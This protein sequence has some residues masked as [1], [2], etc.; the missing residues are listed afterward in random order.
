LGFRTRD[1]RSSRGALR[2]LAAGVGRSAAFAGAIA[3][4][5][6]REP[7]G[8]GGIERIMRRPFVS[9]ITRHLHRHQA[10]ATRVRVDVRLITSVRDKVPMAPFVAA[11]PVERDHAFTANASPAHVAMLRRVLERERRTERSATIRD[12]VREAAAAVASGRA[13]T[14]AA[15]AGSA[16]VVKPVPMI[17]R[18]VSAQASGERPTDSPASAHPEPSVPFAPVSFD[19]ASDRRPVPQLNDRE[20]GRVTEHVVHALERRILAQR[21]RHGRI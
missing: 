10:H 20:L 6:A 3:A 11:L 14:Q 1:I 7:I 17:A 8:F 21:E 13:D 9:V 4:R 15:T 19:L 2:S 5:Y 12:V 18:R 16:R